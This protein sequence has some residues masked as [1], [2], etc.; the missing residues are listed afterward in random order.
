MDAAVEV[1][2]TRDYVIAATRGRGTWLL[3]REVD[4]SA[5]D[6]R[7]LTPHGLSPVDVA[8]NLLALGYWR[9]YDGP[10]DVLSCDISNEIFDLAEE[11]R[12]EPAT[13]TALAAKW[14]W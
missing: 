12:F 11:V 13:S 1:G 5:A 3:V 14:G 6:A 4:D 7:M 9:N 8:G 10:Q 2:A